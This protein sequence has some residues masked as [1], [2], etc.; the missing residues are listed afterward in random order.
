M[1]LS[2]PNI[3][4]DFPFKNWLPSHETGLFEMLKAEDPGKSPGKR[5]AL[6]AMMLGA[7]DPDL[8]RCALPQH[9]LL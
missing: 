2:C 7:S 4:I 3:A 9:L 1:N 5:P 6:K 8:S